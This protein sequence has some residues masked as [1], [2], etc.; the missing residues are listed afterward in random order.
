MKK[1]TNL[2]VEILKENKD[3][4]NKF[5]DLYKKSLEKIDKIKIAIDDLAIEQSKNP[6]NWGYLGDLGYINQS[7]DNIMDFLNIKDVSEDSVK[8]N[9]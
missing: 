9:L 6:R 2:D 4:A 8:Y 7:I 1:F 5:N 3:L